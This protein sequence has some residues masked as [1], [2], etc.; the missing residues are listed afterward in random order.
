VL[1]DHDGRSSLF[2]MGKLGILRELDRR[3][4]SFVVAH[5]LGYQNLVE[6]DPQNGKVQYRRDMIPKLN[7]PLK[8]C[9]PASGIRNWRER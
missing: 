3:T 8:Y 4:G 7:V 2:K 1:I 9:P 6:F 5:D